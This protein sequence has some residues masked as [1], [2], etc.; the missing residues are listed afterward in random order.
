MYI[1]DVSLYSFNFRILWYYNIRKETTYI[2]VISKIA[3]TRVYYRVASLEGHDMCG[4]KK[5]I[6]FD[7]SF[8]VLI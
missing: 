1:L 4:M 3:I 5:Y 6:S 8:R 7:I 2:Q